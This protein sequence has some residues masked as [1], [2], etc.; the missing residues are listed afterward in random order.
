MAQNV[1]TFTESDFNR[2]F[3]THLGGWAAD[4]AWGGHHPGARGAAAR[5]AK[6]T[7]RSRHW[8]WAVTDD[9]DTRGRWDPDYVPI[10]SVGADA[11]LVVRDSG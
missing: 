1:T 7:V 2:T 5:R 10:R 8:N 6:S 4:H 3:P 11:V 9:T